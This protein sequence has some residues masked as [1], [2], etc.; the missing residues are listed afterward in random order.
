MIS[1]ALIEDKLEFFVALVKP[2]KEFLLKF[3]IEAPM[4]LFLGLSLKYLLLAIMGRFLKKE[5]IEEDYTFKKLSPIDPADKKKQKNPKHVDIGFAARGTLK[6]SN[7]K[8]R[9]K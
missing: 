1:A 7:R 8:E 9:W 3:Q 4:T 5:V 6:K 2:L